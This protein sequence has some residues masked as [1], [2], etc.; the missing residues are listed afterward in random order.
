MDDATYR[1]QNPSIARYALT[2]CTY[3]RTRA[4]LV[5]PSWWSEN[6]GLQMTTSSGRPCRR[7]SSTV[8]SP[9][10]DSLRPWT[11]RSS[12]PKCSARSSPTRNA[13]RVPPRFQDPPT[14]YTARPAGRG[15]PRSGSGS[16]R[17]LRPSDRSRPPA[18]PVLTR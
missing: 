9:G 15:S 12:K 1:S 14:T 2:L 11:M 16:G 7:T 13:I 10:F 18:L 4:A 17:R 3:I 5:N 6:D 8:T